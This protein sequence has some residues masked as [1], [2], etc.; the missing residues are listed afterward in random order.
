MPLSSR[1]K[2][3]FETL[4]SAIRNG[5]AALMECQL[6]SSAEPVSVICAVNQD[7]S[8]T[9]AFVPLAQLFANSPYSLLNPPFSDDPGSATPGVLSTG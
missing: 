6:A 4:R 1:D 5:D 2:A 7:P 3:N 9:F 8:G